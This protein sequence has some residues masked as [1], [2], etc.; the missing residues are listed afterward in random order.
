MV[1][2]ILDINIIL[3]KKLF[4]INNIFGKKIDSDRAFEVEKNGCVKFWEQ[5]NGVGGEF[6]EIKRNVD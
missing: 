3:H 2:S 6:F 5:R 1:K 4:M